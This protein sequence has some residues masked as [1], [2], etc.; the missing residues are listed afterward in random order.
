MIER[1]ADP[2]IQVIRNAADHGI[3]S[4]EA[5]LAA[6]KTA[7]GKSASWRAMPAPKC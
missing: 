4:P 6:G 5:R 3:E 7:V 1:L 2:L